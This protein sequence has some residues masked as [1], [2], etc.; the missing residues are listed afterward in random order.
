MLRK[1]LLGLLLFLLAAVVA[2]AK[3][4]QVWMVGPPESPIRTVLA[5]HGGSETPAFA[6]VAS[7]ADARVILVEGLPD[8]ACRSA[9]AERH[10][11]GVGLVL[12]LAPILAAGGQDAEVHAWLGGLIGGPYL[13]ER[14]EGPVSLVA[15]APSGASQ[16]SLATDIVWGGSPQVRDRVVLQ[17][18][19]GP[20][21]TTLVRS[22]EGEE[23][24]IL[25][26]KGGGTWLVGPDLAAPGNAAF[27]EWGYFSYLAVS[28]V[29][30]ASGAEPP[31]FAEWKPSPLPHGPDVF[32]IAILLGLVACSTILLFVVT[33]R[34]SLLNPEALD[35]LVLDRRR[36][37]RAEDSTA[38]ER[39]GFHR[40]LGGFLVTLVLG[41]VMFIP[42]IIYQNLILPN[43]ILPSAQ[44]LGLWGRVTQF[45]QLAW[46][47]FDMG[48]GIA[49][50]KFFSE[51]RVKD[52]RRAIQFGQLYV[53]W[54]AVTGVLQIGIFVIFAASYA[55]QGAFA[56]YSWLI[57]VHAL[58]QVP[59]FFL[60]FRHAF[61]AHQ[62]G[63]RARI[64]DVAQ[65]LLLPM[66][67]QPIFVIMFFAWGRAHPDFGGP[68]AG[69]LGM[70]VAAWTGDFVVFAL[71]YILYR[72]I[73]LDPRPI[74]MAHFDFGIVKEA[75]RFGVFEML[76]SAAWAAGQ[77]MEIAI[78]QGRLVNYAETWGNWMMA[79][80]FVFA[81]AVTTT[82]FDGVM[83]AISE[84]MGRGK[85]E[86]ARYYSAMMYKYGGMMHAF[87]GAVLLAV[88]DRFILGSTGPDFVRAADWVRPLIVWGA[89]QYG[90]WVGDYVQLGSNKP[91]MKASLVGAEQLLR[92]GL[93]LVLSGPLQVPGL[94][95]A[96]FVG[97]A[98]KGIASYFLND[99]LC[100]RQ[101]FYAWQ[102][103]VAP[104]VAGS[105]H[106]FLLRGLSD[107]VWKQEPIT[108]VL[109][110]L[111]GI[112]PSF[113]LYAFMYALAGGWDRPG[114][115]ELKLAAS[116]A[117][118][119]KGFAKLFVY[120]PSEL[121]ARLSPLTGRFPIRVRELA[122]AEAL[123]IDRERV[124]L[125]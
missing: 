125:V 41:L 40:P 30:R 20:D 32:G 50:V 88:A 58:I 84:A 124:R 9:I 36:Y 83:P 66:V 73:G 10:A 6:F 80:N 67:L 28:L 118:P 29:T 35:R 72:R 112:L 12:S 22:W 1:S 121:G 5:R 48:T 123:E 47:V 99:R 81:F 27:R 122:M 53:W 109:L 79:Q 37:E 108:S 90:S 46:Q 77:A 98:S 17:L 8:A 61:I 64:L 52:P 86:L 85:K 38:W 91:W 45:F 92:V 44:A 31:P 54:Q 51:Y 14:R 114:L 18:G 34:R 3:P 87:I 26:L 95:I 82:L 60:V 19:K 23:S 43:Y 69:A 120:W 65:Q 42:L 94:I 76:G 110:F 68:M 103:A 89:I 78:T 96:Y 105:I 75:L 7:P 59:G 106:Y 24:L 111:I 97:L 104:L 13:A 74:F 16:R 101:V 11:A 56:L 117:S 62:R 102:S 119:V 57:V 70:G 33:R 116:L 4:I 107:L 15:V 63:D 93:A 55:P 100:Y 49:F 71:G 113:P 115:E 21:A 2:M 39:A 25:E